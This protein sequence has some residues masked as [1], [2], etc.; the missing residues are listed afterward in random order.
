MGFKYVF[1]VCFVSM[2][3]YL[4]FPKEQLYEKIKNY[5]YICFIITIVLIFVTTLFFIVYITYKI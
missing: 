3:F 5:A 2:L 1:I 4:Y